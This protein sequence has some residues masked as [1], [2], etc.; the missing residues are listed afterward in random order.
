VL[1]IIAVVAAIFWLPSPWGVVA[2]I[3]AAL[4]ELAE[5]G[6]FLWYSRRRKATTGAEGLVGAVGVA[7]TPC[8]PEGRVRVEGELW[9][10]V[11]QEGADQGDRVVVE[12]VEPGLI[13]AVAPVHSAR[14]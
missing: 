2:I 13:L 6:G 11:C 5:M 9:S 4:V 1:L 3:G 8:H 14:G 7:I 12:R 10:A